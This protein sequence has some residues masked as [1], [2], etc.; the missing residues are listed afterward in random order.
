MSFGTVRETAPIMDGIDQN[1][2][3]TNCWSIIKKY[4]RPPEVD[5]QRILLGQRERI[6]FYTLL[7]GIILG[8][9]AYIP[10]VTLAYKEKLWWIVSIDTVFYIG[11]IS[12]LFMRRT[13]FFFRASYVLVVVYG[14]GF[15]F[16]FFLVH[17]RAARYGF[18]LFRC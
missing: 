8:L 11:A 16:F 5:S 6:L 13:P 10:S 2:Y 9:F 18:S 14:L 7:P 4:I 1:K 12:V 17:L 15:S 3:V